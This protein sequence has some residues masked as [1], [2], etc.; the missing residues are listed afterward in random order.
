MVLRLKF[1]GSVNTVYRSY[2][3]LYLLIQFLI[4]S[5]FRLG[6]LWYQLGSSFPVFRIFVLTQRAPGIKSQT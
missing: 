3:N 4:F 6:V 1:K 5:T 2:I